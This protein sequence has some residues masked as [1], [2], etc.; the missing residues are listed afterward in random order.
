MEIKTLMKKLKLPKSWLE[1]KK[2]KSASKR[3]EANFLKVRLGEYKDTG[4]L[5]IGGQI[6]GGGAP[7]S[8][9]GQFSPLV[10]IA[11]SPLLSD[12]RIDSTAI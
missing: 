11:L 7:G 8:K 9:T 2:T 10:S 12:C 4:Q 5:I 1:K 6:P 3:E